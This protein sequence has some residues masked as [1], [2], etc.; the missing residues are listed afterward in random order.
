MCGICGFTDQ[1][2]E[3]DRVD[4]LRDMCNSLVHRGPDSDGFYFN[5]F[6]SMGMRRLAVID[7]DGGSQPMYNEDRSVAVVYNG[8][9]YNYPELKKNLKEKGHRFISDC[10]TEIIPHLYE[11]LGLAFPKALNGM[12]AIALW[13]DTHRRLVLVRDRLGEKPLYY[14][15]VG[16]NR[17]VFGSEIKAV[18]KHPDVITELDLQAIYDY[19]VLGYIP[20]PRTIYRQVRKLPAATVLVWHDGS[21]SSEKYW[22]LPCGQFTHLSRVEATEHLRHLLVDAVR[23]RMLSHVPLGAFLSGGIDSSIVVAV[24]AQHSA[25]PIKTFHVDFGEDRYSECKYARSVA[26]RYGTDHYECNVRPNAVSTLND[27]VPHL[28]EPFGDASA[29]PT[30]HLSQFT[31][32][33]VVVALSGDGG[34]ENFGGYNR[35]RRILE[36]PAFPTGRRAIKPLAR[37]L[38]AVLPAAAPG[39][40]SIATMG[41]DNW[42]FYVVGSHAYEVKKLLHPALLKQIKCRVSTGLVGQYA[43]Q[44]CYQ[45]QLAPYCAFDIHWYLPDDI[46]V[47]VDRMSMA[48]S[49]EVRAPYLDHRVVEFAATLPQAWK[50]GRIGTKLILKD[51]FKQDLP[52]EVLAPRKRGFSMPLDLWMSRDLRPALEDALSDSA[53]ERAHILNLNAMRKLAMEHWRGIRDRSTQLWWFLVF[54]KWWQTIGWRNAPD[55]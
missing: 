28:D 27:I 52:A 51:A 5:N 19:F 26:R 12:Y 8:E 46:L 22:T 53:L 2:L 25:C 50:I 30:W 11:E 43:N 47:K 35:Y 24:M 4:V 31:R 36:R 49:L 39:Y 33:H 32:Q 48:H 40:R 13:D 54:T 20:A 1:T 6:V 15:I 16:G 14:A 55:V 23:R 9:I 44:N 7:I 18:L 17:L 38:A 21:V 3:D 34:D 37:G 42:E 41:M 45:D 29:I 10:D